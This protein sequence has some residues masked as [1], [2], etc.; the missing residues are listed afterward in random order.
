MSY[1][2]QNLHF[3]SHCSSH[4]RDQFT[5]H[6]PAGSAQTVDNTEQVTLFTSVF[7]SPSSAANFSTYRYSSLSLRTL[8]LCLHCSSQTHDHPSTCLSAHDACITNNIKQVRHFTPYRFSP[9]PAANK[10]T[11][12]PLPLQNLISRSQVAPAIQISRL[13]AAQLLTVHIPQ[14][15]SNT[16]AGSFLS[17]SLHSQ[18]QAC[19]H[20]YRFLSNPDVFSRDVLRVSECSPLS[21]HLAMHTSETT[22][23]TSVTPHLVSSTHPRN[24]RECL[25]NLPLILYRASSSCSHTN[26]QSTS[27]PFWPRRISQKEIRSRQ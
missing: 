3:S 27:Y 13:P 21:S 17:V 15:T 24:K 10:Y 23:K 5:S 14:T 8:S 4:T 18:Q 2:I 26:I 25:P 16:A 9:S 12:L 20:T 7:F 6:P 19:T 11:H 1:L 22:P